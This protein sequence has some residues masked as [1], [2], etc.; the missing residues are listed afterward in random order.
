V[1]TVSV[2]EGEEAMVDEQVNY[3]PELKITSFHRGLFCCRLPCRSPDA[4]IASK[5]RVDN[6]NPT[7][8]E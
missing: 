6:L 8:V 2:A 7:A 1:L 4:R 5:P 3:N